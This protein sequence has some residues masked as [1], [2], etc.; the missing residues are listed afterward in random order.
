[1]SLLDEL[2]V[3]AVKDDGALLG[4]SPP[5]LVVGAVNDDGALLGVSPP[6]LVVGVAADGVEP[7]TAPPGLAA[8]GIDGSA[9]TRA[10]GVAVAK[11]AEPVALSPLPS[12]L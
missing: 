4:V 11:R 1:V 3:G 5:E 9:S 7:A 12:T 8:T 10:W 6:E 2:V